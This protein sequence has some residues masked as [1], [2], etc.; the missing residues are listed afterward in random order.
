VTA[1]MNAREV[2]QLLR[3][4]PATLKA[5]LASGRLRGFQ[6]GKVIRIDRR[7]VEELLRGRETSVPA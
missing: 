7:S 1:T 6:Q 5:L 4:T 3:I 2:M